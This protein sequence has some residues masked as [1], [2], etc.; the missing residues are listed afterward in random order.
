M[1]KA[2][3]RLGDYGEHI[4][5]WEVSDIARS[6]DPMYDEESFQDI[7]EALRDTLN[8]VLTVR[9]RRVLEY[10]YGLNGREFS[11]SEVAMMMDLSV[12]AVIRYE[13]TAITKLKYPKNGRRIYE[14]LNTD[15]PIIHERLS[16]NS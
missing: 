14:L 1:A 8:S 5:I 10:L 7:L 9:E 16:S 6:E 13:R 15:G 2:I 4:S 12:E 11:R 3:D